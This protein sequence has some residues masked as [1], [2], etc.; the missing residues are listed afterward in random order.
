MFDN[1]E[2]IHKVMEEYIKDKKHLSSIFIAD[3]EANFIQVRKE[4]HFETRIIKKIN[5]VRYETWIRDN[6]ASLKELSKYNP[7]L[8]PWYKKA[9]KNQFIIS[10]PYI[11]E[12][13]KKLGITVSYA[14]YEN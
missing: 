1:Y 12:S 14:K 2:N 5:N 8:R 9:I 13:T 7:T 10:K 11:F 6:K 3:E 4:P